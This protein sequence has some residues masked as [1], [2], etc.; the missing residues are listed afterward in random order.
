[1]V[2]VFTLVSALQDWMSEILDFLKKE[3]ERL[4][5]EKAEE[6]ER[7]E[8]VRLISSQPVVFVLP[9]SKINAKYVGT[10]FWN[11]CDSRKLPGMEAEI[12]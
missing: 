7:I 9:F 3:K 5:L 6:L 12:Q 8:K 2:M 4:E 10:V 11:Y 1:M